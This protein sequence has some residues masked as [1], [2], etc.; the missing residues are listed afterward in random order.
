MTNRIRAILGVSALGIV[1]VAGAAIGI[2]GT[3][4]D[5][6]DEVVTLAQC[7]AAVQATIQAHLNGGTIIE[8]ERTTDHGGVRYEVDANG[9]A[10]KIEFNVAADGAYLGAEVDDDG[11]QASG[12]VGDDRDDRIIHARLCAMRCRGM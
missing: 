12:Q 1:A 3:A 9:E 6:G 7:P 11:D 8:I 4:G 5:D 10:G 2:R